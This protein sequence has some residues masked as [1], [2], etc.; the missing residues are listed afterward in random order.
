LKVLESNL[1]ADSAQPKPGAML[2]E[3]S[4]LQKKLKEPGLRILD[5]RPQTD[6]ANGHVSGAVRVDVKTWQAI[7]K[8]DGGFRDSKAWGAQ[9]G[10]LGITHESKVAVYGA[11]L[12]DTAR[13]WWTLKYLGVENVMVVNGGWDAWTKE[14]LPV[15]KTTVAPKATDFQPRFQADRLEEIDSLKKDL[16][17][18]KV[19]VVDARSQGEFT[20]KQA[21]GKKGGHIP[22]A[23]HLE[24]KE[25]LAED[26]RFKSPEQLRRLFRERGILPDD[27]AVCY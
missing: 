14:K 21:K 1:F 15:E 7:G 10:Q 13:I 24:W 18:P 5:T 6:F 9:V 16:K 19:K 26:G 23:A 27:T 3:V 4:E 8:K 22:G 12:T 11:T 17:A 20:G 2:I 25:L